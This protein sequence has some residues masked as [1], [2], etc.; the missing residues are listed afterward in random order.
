MKFGPG[1]GYEKSN[2][3]EFHEYRPSDSHTEQRKC[4]STRTFHISYYVGEI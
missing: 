3:H 4:V 2:R 1:Y